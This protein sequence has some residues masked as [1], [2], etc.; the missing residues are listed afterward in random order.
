[1]KTKRNITL[2][3]TSSSASSSNRLVAIDP[4][5]RKIG[6]AS[7]E[8]EKLTDYIVRD[9]PAA[10]SVRDRLQSL[11]QVLNRYL[12]EKQPTQIALEKTTFSS[13]TQNGLL[14]LAYYKILALARR[15]RIPVYEYV[16]ISIRKTVC[17]N[18]HAT[19]QDV[20]KILVS[21]FPELRVFSGSTRRYQTLHF[22]NMFDAIA[23]GVTHIR[24]SRKNADTCK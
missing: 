4:G 18:G 16:P 8:D 7:F 13:A 15:R 10:R 17:G 2:N 23:V 3:T 24:R 11:E 12:D 14:V 21:R 6:L 9:I 1:M 20:M 19:K 5:M 22:F